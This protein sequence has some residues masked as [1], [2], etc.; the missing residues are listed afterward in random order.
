MNDRA[1]KN[2]DEIEYV[3]AHTVIKTWE[4]E[5]QMRQLTVLTTIVLVSMVTPAMAKDRTKEANKSMQACTAKTSGACKLTS[6]AK[7]EEIIAK[8]GEWVSLGSYKTK[9]GARDIY[10]AVTKG[11]KLA[12]VVVDARGKK[13][14]FVPVL[15]SK[16]S[17]K[18][19]PVAFL[20]AKKAASN[21]IVFDA[22]DGVSRQISL[23]G[24]SSF[25]GG[26]A[27]LDMGDGVSLRAGNINVPFG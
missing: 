3:M 20:S 15:E 2:P 6:R 13:A 8:K 27:K 7:A 17:K 25:K 12:L 11:G 9:S 23:G 10:G 21:T 18:S 19:G 16:G 22:G 24:L 14:A 4:R 26:A 5:M 1:F